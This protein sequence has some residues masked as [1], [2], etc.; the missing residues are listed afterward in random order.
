MCLPSI[1]MMPAA[2]I[3]AVM[4]ATEARAAALQ[5][6]DIKSPISNQTATGTGANSIAIAANPIAEKIHCGG[7]RVGGGNTDTP[8]N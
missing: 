3:E 6:L 5:N 4:T 7:K 2:V 8:R 1:G